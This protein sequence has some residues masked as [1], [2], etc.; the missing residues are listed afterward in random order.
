MEIQFLTFAQVLEI[1]QDQILRYGGKA[2]IRDVGLLKSALGMPAAS[3]AGQYLHTNACE[4]AA[5]Y[6]FHL[7]QNHPFA[8]GNK[9]VG[10]VSALIFLLLNGYEFGAPEYELTELVFDVAKGKRNKAEATVF[11][12]YWSKKINR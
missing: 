5:A 8:D 6:L 10:T 12:Q 4:M 9:R 3:Y 1:H 11:I 2:G 7:V